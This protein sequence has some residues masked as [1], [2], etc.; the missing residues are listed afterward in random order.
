M[1]PGERVLDWAASSINATVLEVANLKPHSG[2][3]RLHVR[4][5]AKSSNVVLRLVV[6]GWIGADLIATGAAALR[7]AERHGLAAPRL[8]ACDLDGCQAGEVATLETMLD[9]SSAL[10][11]HVSAERL[12]A[13]GAA[14]AK[15]HAIP[16]EPQEH[17][18]LRIRP[19][20]VDDRAMERRWA[21]AFQA[22][23]EDEKPAV[24]DALSE[25]TGWSHDHA[26]EVAMGDP[27][28]GLLQLADDRIRDIP[29]P[30][31]QSVFLHG[32]IWGGNMLWENDTCRALIDW[33]TAGAGD[34]GVDLGE[35]R[36]QMA[37][38]YGL[39]AAIHVQEGWE[40]E[41]GRPASNVAY[42]DLVAALNTPTVMNGW[43]GFDERGGRLDAQSVTRRR[44]EFLR[45]ALDQL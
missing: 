4:Q 19:T 16:F 24:I 40:D 9:G 35:L 30:Q 28:T 38:Q 13:A 7:V 45:A 41:S 2:P 18:P 39:W 32:D 6:P 31:G 12:R 42:W 29:R 11:P 5:G 26:Q 3:W 14:I 34:P 10:P 17:L 22:A 25:L 27:A 8:L 1:P 23:T 37:H 33:K 36:M 44:D 20:Q 15:V 21:T 43:P